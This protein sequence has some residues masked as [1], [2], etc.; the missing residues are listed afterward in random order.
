ML[1]YVQGV[2]VCVCLLTASLTHF[3]CPKTLGCGN[4]ICNCPP[5]NGRPANGICY[6][7]TAVL[8][9]N[10]DEDGGDNYSLGWW[11]WTVKQAII[12]DGWIQTPQSFGKFKRAEK[13]LCGSCNIR[14]ELSLWFK[15]K[16][17]WH[18]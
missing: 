9:S 13:Y 18:E 17:M 16:V 3:I 14:F 6:H 7:Q 4:K 1:N 15:K 8:P 10:L 2:C 11:R 5:E 12:R